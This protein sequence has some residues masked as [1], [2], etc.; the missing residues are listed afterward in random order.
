MSYELGRD[1]TTAGRINAL[2]P[3]GGGQPRRRGQTWA[4][5]YRAS[6]SC[7]L[8]SSARFQRHRQEASPR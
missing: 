2:T 7:R 6:C 8:H 4:R 1:H 3:L 5:T